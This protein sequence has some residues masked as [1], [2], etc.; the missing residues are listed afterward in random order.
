MFIFISII[1]ILTYVSHILLL[2]LVFSPL[3]QCHK[4]KSQVGGRGLKRHLEF[5][6]I[7][8]SVNYNSE[9]G[10]EMPHNMFFSAAHPLTMHDA[11][12][13]GFDPMPRPNEVVVGYSLTKKKQ[14]SFSACLT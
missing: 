6:F 12:V 9:K 5:K 2:S 3:P 1:E 13:F 7:I 14:L 10:L 8:H 4:R 11:I